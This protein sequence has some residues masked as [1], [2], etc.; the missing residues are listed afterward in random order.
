MSTRTLV[1]RSVF[2]SAFRLA[3][4]T[5]AAFGP[6]AALPR[7]ASA[8]ADGFN[9]CAFRSFSLPGARHLAPPRPGA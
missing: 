4:A 1:P 2:R 7:T 5:L 8:P 3:L 6:A 9:S